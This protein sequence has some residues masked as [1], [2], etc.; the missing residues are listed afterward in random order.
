M[1][2]FYYTALI[3]IIYFSCDNIDKKKNSTKGHTIDSASSDSSENRAFTTDWT[4]LTKDYMTWYSY[5][6]YNIRLSQDFIGIDIDSQKIDKET[7]LSKLMNENVVAYK[8]KILEG[9]PV[10]QL[11]KLNSNDENIKATSKQ[12][13]STEFEHFKM[14]GTEIPDFSFIDLNGTVYNKGNT[15]GKTLVLKCWFIHCVA[16]VKEFPELNKLVDK[17]RK[18]SDVLFISLA[19]DSKEELSKFL[20]TKIFKYATVPEM[21]S[22]MTDKLNIT[23][24]PTHL[25]VGKNGKIEKVVNSV[26]DLKPFLEREINYKLDK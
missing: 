8:T 20:Q 4:K 14:E 26:D 6:Y 11:F 2:I 1:R 15:K 22:Y 7:F 24:Y 10:Y 5:T 25:L 18:N 19:M 23:Q 9:K 21:E 13:A 3:A 17:Y 12:R 16:C